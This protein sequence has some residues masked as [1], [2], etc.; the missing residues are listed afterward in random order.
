MWLSLEVLKALVVDL[1][2]KRRTE[3]VVAPMFEGVHQGEQLLLAHG[4]FAPRK[5][6]PRMKKQHRAKV[7]D[8]E[9]PCALCRLRHPNYSSS[10]RRRRRNSCRAGAACHFGIIIEAG[11]SS[12]NQAGIVG[13]SGEDNLTLSVK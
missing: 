13:A 12:T 7:S 2:L 6:R 5:P 3:Q 4:N 9:E 1:D 10:N 11:Y 8:E